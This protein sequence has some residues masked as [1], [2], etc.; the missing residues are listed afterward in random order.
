MEGSNWGES[1]AKLYE[2]LGTARQ[3]SIQLGKFLV[4]TFCPKLI[5]GLQAVKFG[6][7]G[8]RDRIIPTYTVCTKRELAR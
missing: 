8:K 3:T 6:C 7:W 4:Y 1:K 2:L 5:K